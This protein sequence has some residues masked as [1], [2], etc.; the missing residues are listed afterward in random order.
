MI[1]NNNKEVNGY[2][3]TKQWFD[4]ASKNPEKI[5]PNHCALY[6]AI[7]ELNNQLGWSQNFG[8]PTSCTMQLIGIR[9]YKTFK[10]AFDE[11]VEWG[12]VRVIEKSKNQYTANIITLV[13]FPTT[14][15]K[16]A[17]SP[18]LQINIIKDDECSGKNYQSTALSNTHSTAHIIKQE[19]TIKTIKTIKGVYSK[20]VLEQEK[21]ENSKNITP[22]E[23]KEDIITEEK[24]EEEDYS[25]IKI[26]NDHKEKNSTTPDEKEKACI[27]EEDA[28]HKIHRLIKENYH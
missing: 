24:E 15:G 13:K 27:N 22:D 8:L 20:E 1:K 12:F 4:F 11:L 17:P 26:E 5:Y 7:V 21:E 10:K 25:P 18:N 3:Y 14:K 28:D 2:I 19:E 9:N 23:K 16:V 6:I